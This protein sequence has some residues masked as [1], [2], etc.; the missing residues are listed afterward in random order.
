MYKDAR[1][2]QNLAETHLNNIVTLADVNINRFIENSMSSPVTVSKTMANDSF[3]KT[4]MQGEVK[5]RNDSGYLKKLYDY[6]SAYQAK[7][8]YSTVFCVSAL[9]GRYYYQTGLNKIV[10]PGDS[11]DVWYYNFVR[12]GQE[13]DLEVDT[14]QEDKNSITIFVNFRVEDT[15]GNLLGVIGVAQQI[16]S[17]E[18]LIRFYENNYHL[19]VYILNT[20]TVKTSFSGNSEIFIDRKKLRE[21]SGNTQTVILNKTGDAVLQWFTDGGKLKCIIS[22]YNSTLGWYL[23]VEKDTETISRSFQERIRHNILFMLITLCACIAVTTVILFEYNELIVKDENRDDVTGLQNRKLFLKQS[24]VYIRRHTKQPL[25]LFM[26]D[27]DNFKNINDTYGHIFGNAV[28]GTVGKYLKNATDG[29]GFAARWG[30]DEFIGILNGGTE[31]SEHLLN[32]FVTEL[33]KTRQ[34]DRC[35]V[36]LSIGIVKM[37]PEKSFEQNVD[38]ADAA[39]YR[40]K[41]NGRD[42]I[43][44][45]GDV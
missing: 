2:Y 10:S 44:I 22:K 20:S 19:S 18:S 15:D 28:L 14:N 8:G 25:T 29:C 7:Y 31:E 6:L 1:T 12:S 39:L 38:N 32:S 27:I 30:G 33:K 21:L 36:T 16:D 34:N 17:L 40:S 35:C 3:L 23:I 11:H 42:Q 43:T 45:C 24:L 26:I 5:Y 37:D 13:Y 4:W 41:K 9:T